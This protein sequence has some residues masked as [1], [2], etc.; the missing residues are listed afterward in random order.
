MALTVIKPL[1]IGA[2]IPE[3]PSIIEDDSIQ[4]L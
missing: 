2:M 3:E 1:G 4:T